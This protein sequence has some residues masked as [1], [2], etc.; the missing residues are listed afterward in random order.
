MEETNKRGSAER[1]DQQTEKL[2]HPRIYAMMTG[3]AGWLVLSVWMFSG[4]GSTDYLLTIVSGFI[5]IAVALP[6][7]LSRLR[8][9]GNE[10]TSLRKWG[11]LDFDTWTGRLRGSQAATEILLPIAAVAFGMT[12]FG[13]VLHLV[14]RSVS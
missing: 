12:A 6:F 1:P 5:F 2:L 8:R 9:D 13:I 14:E 10:V 11:S 4:A 3:L 7:I